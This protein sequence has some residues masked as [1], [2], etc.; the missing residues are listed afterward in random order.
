MTTAEILNEIHKLPFGEQT[1]LKEKLLED[2]KSNGL[3][4]KADDAG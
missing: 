1:I 3:T 2:F 4:K